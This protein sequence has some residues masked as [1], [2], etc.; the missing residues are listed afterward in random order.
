MTAPSSYAS[1]STPTSRTCSRSRRAGRRPAVSADVELDE[2]TIIYD[3]HLDGRRRR[4]RV[5]FDG[6]PVLSATGATWR[7]TVRARSTWT[8]GFSVDVGLGEGW[9]SSPLHA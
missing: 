1:T 4:V 8:V 9:S 6:V 7:G 3:W 5:R 2:A